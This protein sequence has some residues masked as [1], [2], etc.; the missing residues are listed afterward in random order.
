MPRHDSVN[1]TA[2]TPNPHPKR[3]LAPHSYVVLLVETDPQSKGHGALVFT[4]P[5]GEKR[6][7][8]LMRET[9]PKAK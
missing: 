1:L 9:A 4:G 3:A 2:L 5:E 7:E 8:T 6:L